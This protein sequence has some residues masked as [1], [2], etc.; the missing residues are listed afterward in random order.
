MM[1]NE[2]PLKVLHVVGRMG[3]GGQETMIMNIYRKMNLSKIQFDFL[4]HTTEKNFYD[5][6]I[7]QLGGNIYSVTQKSKNILK[8]MAETYRTIKQGNYQAIHVHTASSIVA[9][10][11]FLAWCA[12]VKIRI[13]HSHNT[14]TQGSRLHKLFMPFLNTFSTQQFACSK[15]AGIW[16]YGENAIEKLHIINNAIDSKHYQYN[17][18]KAIAI[19][20]NLGISDKFVLIHVGRFNTVKNHTFL[21][22]IFEEVVKRNPDSMLLL[23][24]DGDLKEDIQDKITN[25]KLNDR[26][27]L[28]GLR[29]DIPDLL[30]AA[31]LFVM[32]SL[33]EGLPVSLIEAQSSGLPCIV[34]DTITKE[35]DISGLLTFV[36]LNDPVQKWAERIVPFSKN[37]IRKNT[38]K[39]ITQSGY[40]I[41]EVAHTLE[42]FYCSGTI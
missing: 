34:S 5:D 21:I 14:S 17:Q 36:S 9:I 41:K 3:C 12:G 27:K 10:D 1:K 24:G 30:Q 28:L 11:L 19:K 25:R 37:T 23:V 6:E 29:N 40:D 38:E 18:D 26:V 35:T 16:L 2:Q 42:N 22:D 33:H 7:H 31:D 20:K 39:S 15:E 13:S 4:V 32:P 8:S